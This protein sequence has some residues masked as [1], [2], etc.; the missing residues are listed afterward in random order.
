MGCLE[1]EAFSG[2]VIDS[3]HGEGDI[4]LRGDGIPEAHLLREELSDEAVH[5]LVGATLPGGIGMSDP[6]Q[7]SAQDLNRPDG[8]EIPA[9]FA[10]PGFEQC[11]AQGRCQRTEPAQP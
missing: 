8:I 10:T 6:D 9:I 2:T 1:T 3:M 11:F 7:R 5:V 4:S